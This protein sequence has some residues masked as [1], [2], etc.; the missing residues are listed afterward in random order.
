VEE[1]LLI[2]VQLLKGATELSQ[3]TT[4]PVFPERVSV[5]LVEPEQMSEPPETLPATVAVLTVTVAGAEL[6]AVQTPL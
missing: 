4:D 3:F 5:P 6:A 1:V 2:A